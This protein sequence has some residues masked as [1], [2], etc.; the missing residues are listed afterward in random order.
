MT[1]QTNG[2]LSIKR[3]RKRPYW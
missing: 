1:H 3:L 2:I